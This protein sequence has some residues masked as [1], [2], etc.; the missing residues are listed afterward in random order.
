M[1]RAEP[2]GQGADGPPGGTPGRGGAAGDAAGAFPRSAHPIGSFLGDTPFPFA[3]SVSAEGP[4]GLLLLLL[5]FFLH[6]PGGWCD[7]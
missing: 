4:G 7:F 3:S 6:H 5:L 1:A 2:A